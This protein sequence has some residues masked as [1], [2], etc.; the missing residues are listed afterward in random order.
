MDSRSLRNVLPDILSY[1]H[2]VGSLSTGESLSFGWYSQKVAARHRN[3]VLVGRPSFLLFQ[4]CNNR[5]PLKPCTKALRAYVMLPL[6][7]YARSHLITNRFRCQLETGGNLA[8]GQIFLR[9]RG[10]RQRGVGFRC[11]LVHRFNRALCRSLACH[12]YSRVAV[13]GLG[14]VG[15]WEASTTW[16]PLYTQGSP[17]R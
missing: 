8:D 3:R 15:W 11:C 13:I 6:D 2:C 17:A 7:E 10:S 1:R 4:P 9:H 5:A 14:G 12:R 16:V